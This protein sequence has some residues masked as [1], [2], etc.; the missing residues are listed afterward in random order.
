[1][2][3]G[4]IGVGGVGGFFGGKIARFL[5]SAGSN[6]HVSFL[7]RG[8]H[9]SAIR[10][11]GLTL[12]TEDDGEFNCRPDLA[13]DRVSDLPALDVCLV[14]VKS[15]DLRPVAERL[16]T[17]ITNDTIVLPL[18]N[19]IDIHERLRAAVA[20]GVILPACVYV[21]THIEAPGRVLQKGG[22]CTIIYG[23]DP[24]HPGQN[25]TPLSGLLDSPFRQPP[26]QETGS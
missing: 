8:T 10:E 22:G 17:K 21:G 1:M 12:V 5:A 25:I 20:G 19:G 13:T 6:D 14:C 2:N 15:Y 24:A 11:R 26:D 18:L 3:I 9:L 16:S 7:A 23:P 4:I